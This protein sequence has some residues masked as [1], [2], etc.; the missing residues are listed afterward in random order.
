MIELLRIHSLADL[1]GLITLSISVVSLV[2]AVA[3]YR[4]V[5]R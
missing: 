5:Q 4:E 2:V 1:L 3:I